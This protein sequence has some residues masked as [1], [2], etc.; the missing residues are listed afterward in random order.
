VRLGWVTPAGLAIFTGNV[1]GK[2]VNVAAGQ[3]VVVRGSTL[4]EVSV[5]VE[6]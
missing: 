2:A 1:S 6:A 4:G 5:R 3:T